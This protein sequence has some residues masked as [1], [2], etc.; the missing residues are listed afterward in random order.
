V[1][2]AR[3]VH[4]ALDDPSARALLLDAAPQMGRYLESQIPAARFSV[5]PGEGHMAAFTHS[6]EITAALT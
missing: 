6:E 3:R 1:V 2:A 4:R 5:Y